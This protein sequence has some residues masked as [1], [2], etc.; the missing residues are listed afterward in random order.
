MHVSRLFGLC[1]FAVLLLAGVSDATAAEATRCLIADPTDRA[2]NVRDAP[3]GKV[4]NRLRNGREVEIQELGYDDK[5]RPWARVSGHYK[6]QWRNWGWVFHRYLDCRSPADE[7]P[8]QTQG[9]P[10]VFTRAEDVKQLGFVLADYGPDGQSVAHFAN[11][12]HYYGD[13]G[14]DISISAEMLRVYEGRGFTLSSLCMAMVS[15]ILFDPETGT[16]LPSYLVVDEKSL[17]EMGFAEAGVLSEELPIDVPA[18]FARGLPLSDCAFNYHPRTGV[19]LAAATRRRFAEMGAEIVAAMKQELAAGHFASEC[20]CEAAQDFQRKCR[21]EKMG[22][23]PDEQYVVGNLGRENPSYTPPEEARIGLFDVSPTLPLGFG[24]ALFADG[25]A[26]PSGEVGS[27][28]LVLAGQNRAT[29]ARIQAV[30][31]A[32]KQN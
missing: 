32:R 9:Y 1:G 8:V 26:G 10:L 14:N 27:E 4:I 17:R 30:L 13:G 22:R 2:L 5:A 18:C 29:Q 24:Y 28:Q 15:G 3:G 19:K 21:V 31:N 7:V 20:T 6:G 23:C 25:T 16:R 12:C 11:R